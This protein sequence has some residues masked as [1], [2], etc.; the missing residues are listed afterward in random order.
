MSFLKIGKYPGA[1]MNNAH[2]K[3]L[4]GKLPSINYKPDL[5]FLCETEQCS[6]QFENLKKG[7]RIY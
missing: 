3:S 7:L 4:V 6:W 5:V 1:L 2:T